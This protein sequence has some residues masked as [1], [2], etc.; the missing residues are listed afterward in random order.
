MTARPE[1]PFPDVVTELGLYPEEAFHFVRQ[2]LNYAVEKI[3]GPATPE[4]L[5]LY[6]LLEEENME[7][8]DLVDAYE[9]GRL[10]PKVA[11]AVEAAGGL[12]HFNRH[13]SGRELSWGLR[14]YALKR[15]GLMARTVLKRWGIKETMDFGRIVFAMVDNGYMQKQPHDSVD[16]F[17]NVFDFHEALDQAYP[18]G[19]GH[20]D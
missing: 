19:S 14:D 3:H 2:G 4:Q 8:T 16:D 13:V 10:S 1:K 9:S 20:D 6:A 5:A 12:E 11:K 7:L 17:R 15:W 18:P